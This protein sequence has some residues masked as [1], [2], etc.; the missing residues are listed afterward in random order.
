M[1]YSAALGGRWLGGG[2]GK[3]WLISKIGCQ[4]SQA[5]NTERVMVHL[6]VNA[7]KSLISY[8]LRTLILIKMKIMLPVRIPQVQT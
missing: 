3:N 2:G 7:E 8:I 4:K 6:T 1:S 5:S